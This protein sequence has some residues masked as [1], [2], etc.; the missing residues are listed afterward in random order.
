M[1]DPLNYDLYIMSWTG[2]G[3]IK[4]ICFQSVHFSSPRDKLYITMIS[5]FFEHR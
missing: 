3:K 5:I 1:I 2:V 4:N